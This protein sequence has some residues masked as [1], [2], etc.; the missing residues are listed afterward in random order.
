MILNEWIVNI[1]DGYITFF[2]ETMVV[3]RIP[4]LSAVVG[5]LTY[6]L[7]VNDHILFPLATLMPLIYKS[8]F[9]FNKKWDSKTFE[10]CW[11]LRVFGPNICKLMSYVN[12]LKQYWQS[13]FAFFSRYLER[14]LYEKLSHDTKNKVVIIW[15]TDFDHSIGS[16]IPFYWKLWDTIGYCFIFLVDNIMGVGWN[17]SYFALDYVLYID[18]FSWSEYCIGVP[19]KLSLELLSLGGN[20]LS[21]S[22]NLVGLFVF[23]ELNLGMLAFRTIVHL[24]GVKCNYWGLV[25]SLY[26][27]NIS[28]IKSNSFRLY[29][30]FG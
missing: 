4:D 29:F 28:I 16:F 30:R 24:C 1:K 27:L 15:F 10:C 17:V 14:F 7:G 20:I 21:F 19:L 22:V 26:Q 9:F 11:Q 23:I 25:P 18:C 13:I 3:V 2:C 8:R 6:S 12:I 5:G